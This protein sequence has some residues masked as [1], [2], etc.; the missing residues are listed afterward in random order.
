MH[1]MGIVQSMMDIVLQQAEN[2]GAR[3]IVKIS[4]EFG[5]LTGVMPD[6]VRFAFDVLARGT[7]AENAE[8]DITIIPLQT[9]CIDCSQIHIMETYEPFCPNC[10]SASLHF[11]QGRDEMRVASIEI[12]D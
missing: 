1:E 2:S 5:A 4:L 8:L 11:V 12:E 6:A 9:Y 10:K 7:M 3:K